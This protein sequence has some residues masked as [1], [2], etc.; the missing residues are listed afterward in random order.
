MRQYTKYM[1][2]FLSALLIFI[3]IAT[4]GYFSEEVT[5]PTDKPSE[6]DLKIDSRIILL[7]RN[8]PGVSAQGAVL[9]DA[10]DDTVLMAQLANTRLPMA[11]TTK[12]MTAI[13]AIENCDINKKVKVSDEAIG[14]EGSS[15]YLQKGEILKMEDLIYALMLESANDAAVAIAVEVAGS[16]EKF[17]DMMN[18]KAEEL[19]LKDTHFMNP[20][21]L[22]HEE[23]YTTAFEL[24]K[25]A[26]YGLKNEQFKKIV[27]TKKYITQNSEGNYRAFFNH[28]RML[29][30][31]NGAIGV[32]TGYTK[33]T[34]RC[35]VSAA[36][37][38]GLMLVAVTLNDPNDWRDH[39]NMLDFGFDNYKRIKVIDAS[40]H[41]YNIP[42]VG[43]LSD[44]I[45]AG[46]IEDISVRTFTNSENKVETTV[47]LKRF[48]YAPIEKNDVVGEVV[49]TLDGEVVATAPIVALEDIPKRKEP[50]FFNRFCDK[51]KSWFK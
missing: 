27:S 28:N 46:V 32:K 30:V 43:G 5:L 44:Y 38:D 41:H 11:S 29:R 13:V 25:I 40:E 1:S 8:A 2:F 17:A 36:E 47:Q 16:V 39:R 14:V 18:K 7:S 22:D 9:I 26:S 49:A 31:Y 3:P 50:G 23:H 6:V 20:H 35:L 45:K 34:G 10:Y 12:I 42:V 19:G 33:R 51:I 21:G 48:C 4:A 37:R 24:A 15:I